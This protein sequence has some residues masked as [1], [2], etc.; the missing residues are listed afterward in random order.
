ME[1]RPLR[2]LSETGV[3]MYTQRA[4]AA[5]PMYP[6]V[7]DT[8][9]TPKQVEKLKRVQKAQQDT[10]ERLRQLAQEA[11]LRRPM[12]TGHAIFE[13][14][15]VEPDFYLR[16]RDT[17]DYVWTPDRA[18]AAWDKA[19]GRLNRFLKD[20]RYHTV[21]LLV[22]IP[23]SGKSTW[24]A[25]N[26]QHGH[27]YFDATF[28]TAQQ[29]RPVIAMAKRAGRKVEAAVMTA[30]IEVC[31][32]RNKCRPKDRQVPNDVVEKMFAR[33]ITD[34]PT[35][36]EGFD[37]IQMVPYTGEQTEAIEPWQMA[38]KGIGWDMVN[39]ADD[40]NASRKDGAK[41]L[42][43]ILKGVHSLS[44]RALKFNPCGR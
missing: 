7:G 13:Q 22:G 10:R 17:G 8:A 21:T 30:P 24:I 18:K 12:R 38:L 25:K 14:I 40:P 16:D 1:R 3:G 39:L 26:K 37:K 27:I 2:V 4:V 41:K 42:G 19:Y 31:L 15:K 28:T 29:R 23:A 34:L 44:R 20:G 35:A 5:R 6:M 32:D 11:M 33:L 43:D 9:L 36:A